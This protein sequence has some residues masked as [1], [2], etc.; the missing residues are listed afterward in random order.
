MDASETNP[1]ETRPLESIVLLF[2]ACSN[3]IAKMLQSI[4]GLSA[5]QIDNFDFEIDAGTFDVLVSSGKAG[6][7]EFKVEVDA[8][9][10]FLCQMLHIDLR[11]HVG[12]SA[13]RTIECT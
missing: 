8:A 3:M 13:C 9:V 5:L 2:C 7:L 12:A 11:G 10:S 4:A 6:P 1:S